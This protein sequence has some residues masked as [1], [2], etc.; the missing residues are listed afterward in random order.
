MDR[1][2]ILLKLLVHIK[3]KRIAREM[4]YDSLILLE[5]IICIEF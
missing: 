5:F 3:Y 1:A 2:N 4:D